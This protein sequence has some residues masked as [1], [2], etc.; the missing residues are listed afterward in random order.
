MPKVKI[1]DKKGLVQE[2]GSGLEVNGASKFS[3]S[4]EFSAAHQISGN[5]NRVVEVAS[6]T[7]PGSSDPRV[8]LSGSDSGKHF[9]VGDNVADYKIVIP[10]VQGWHARFMVTGSGTTGAVLTNN[11]FL[12]ASADFA[13]A[14]TR[15]PFRGT[16]LKDGGGADSTKIIGGTTNA[17]DIG[18]IT[19][20]KG[21]SGVDGG[22][23]VDVEVVSTTAATA[24]IVIKGLS[25]N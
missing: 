18:M 19:F 13:I 20:I 9:I 8:E 1:T 10:A 5:T 24:T 14:A 23:Y 22:D 2:S 16:V 11:V 12:S 3:N 21:G 25:A 4:V 15:N 17:D 6:A 7:S